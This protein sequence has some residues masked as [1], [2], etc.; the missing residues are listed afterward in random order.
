[1]TAAQASASGHALSGVGWL[2]LHFD[3]SRAIYEAMA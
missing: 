3:R 2:D 1:V